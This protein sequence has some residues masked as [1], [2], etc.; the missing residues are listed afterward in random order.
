MHGALC[1]T[2]CAVQCSP[3]LTGVRQG[4]C[5]VVVEELLPSRARRAA[6]LRAFATLLPVSDTSKALRVYRPAPPRLAVAAPSCQHQH[7][8]A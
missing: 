4:G 7:R 2:C 5:E 3:R 1:L 6:G 8:V